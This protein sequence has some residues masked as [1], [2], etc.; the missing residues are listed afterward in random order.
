MGRKMEA[1]ETSDLPSP[2]KRASLPPSTSQLP[3]E[4]A[5]SWQLPHYCWVQVTGVHCKKRTEQHP[6]DLRA[7]WGCTVR[8][9][10]QQNKK[11]DSS[12]DVLDM[13]N[14]QVCWLLSNA[15]S[16]DARTCTALK[17]SHKVICAT[18]MSGAMLRE[19]VCYSGHS[20]FWEQGMVSLAPCC[21]TI[22]KS[23][24]CFFKA[25][26]PLPSLMAFTF[27]E[28]LFLLSV[29]MDLRIAMDYTTDCSLNFVSHRSWQR[30]PS[31]DYFHF[32]VCL[33]YLLPDL[34]VAYRNSGNICAHLPLCRPPWSVKNV[35][36]FLTSP[37]ELYLG[38][39]E[40]EMLLTQNDTRLNCSH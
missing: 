36:A 33:L 15:L 22:C 11:E 40:G 21:F 31:S 26:L 4:R 1:T 23:Q 30:C 35:T 28:S 27:F 37:Q 39:W 7:T 8:W 17:L 3:T 19:A 14:G 6:C 34:L 24:C 9:H 32:G 29:Q 25:F 16:C 20:T 18:R 12:A 2:R 5:F 13:R 38:F 10:W